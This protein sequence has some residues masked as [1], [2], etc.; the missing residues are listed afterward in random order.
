MGHSAQGWIT[1]ATSWAY[2]PQMETN[3]RA[4]KTIDQRFAENVKR[5]RIEKGF[6]TLEDLVAAT[7]KLGPE[8][9]ISKSTLS[10]I[11]SQSVRGPKPRSALIEELE[12]LAAVF[13]VEVEDLLRD[14]SSVD[15][16]EFH[17]ARSEWI[18][19]MHFYKMHR[20]KVNAAWD[21]MEK[22]AG[23]NEEFQWW[24]DA[25]T[26][27]GV[28]A[29]RPEGGPTYRR[30]SGWILQKGDPKFNWTDEEVREWEKQEADKSPYKDQTAE[31]FWA[32]V[33][34]RREAREKGGK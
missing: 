17:R 28:D 27:D 9:K 6:K 2:H 4:G 33:N 15:E 34:A 21:R 32:G 31:E 26:F 3:E 29:E 11:E 5:L 23:D 16:Q 12:T 14:S 7:E 24:L 8:R 13:G 19:E 22:I 30:V 10:R 18:A 1:L 20:K 25:M